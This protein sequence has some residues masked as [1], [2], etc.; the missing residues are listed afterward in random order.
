MPF[1]SSGLYEIEDISFVNTSL[2]N[3]AARFFKKNGCYTKAPEGSRDFNQHW[4]IEEDRLKNGMSAPGQLIN[5]N[6]IPTIKEIHITGE[7]YGFLNYGRILRTKEDDIN[8]LKNVVKDSPLLQNARKVGKKDLDFPSF[9]DGQYHWFKAKEFAAENGLNIVMSKSRRKGYS[10]MEG[11]D[12]AL[13]IN[14]NRFVTVLIGAYDYKYITLGNQIMP[15]AKRYLDFLELNTDFRRGYLKEQPEHIKMGYKRPTEG[16]K[17]FGYRSEL[18]GVSFMNNPDAAVGKD[19]IKIKFEECGKFPNL[20]EA[21]DVTL[22][23]TE[24]GSIITGQIIM[25]GTGGT[26]DANW[27]DFEDIYYN[28]TK[29]NCMAF[30]NVWD[31]AARGNGVG[32]F[33]PQ[34]IGDP[35]FVDKHGNSLVENAITYSEDQRNKKKKN[36]T[37]AEY[38]KYIGQRARNP[39]E[40]FASGSDNIFPSAELLDQLNKVKHDPDYKYLLRQGEL[41]RK[42]T[43]IKFEHNHI[44]SEKGL[45]IHDP[46]LEFPLKS[47]QDVTGC[48]VEW[49]SPYRDKTTGEIPKGLYRVWHDPY[50]H[51]KNK[52]DITIKDSLGATYVYERLNNITPGKGDYLVASYVGRPER[53]DDY[54]ENLLKICEYWN[55]ELMFENDRGDVKRYFSVNK[56]LHLLANEPDLEWEAE[57][58]GKTNRGKGMNM[59]EKRKAKGAIYLRDWLLEKRGKDVFGNEKLNLHYIYDASLLNELLKWNNKGNFDRVSSLLVGMFDAKECFNREIKVPQTINKNSFFNRPLFNR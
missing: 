4:D 36:L 37:N 38:L 23:T 46:V 10:Y 12:C 15:M 54:N 40:A 39:K 17:E 50:A 22:S 16:N 21:L 28:P 30:D 41:I 47:G 57:L 43:G 3:E 18:V 42:E 1:N 11:W 14:M 29:Y 45:K 55:A 8:N 49:I 6:G 56:K 52:K 5:L 44:L 19:A 9:L 58:R 27:A 2:F 24:D 31:E 20:K 26:D 48:Y 25:F 7:H 53:M 59:T 13:T 33:H 51:D 35:A 32:F 34:Q